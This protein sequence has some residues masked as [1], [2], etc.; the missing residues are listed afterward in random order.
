MPLSKFK[1]E[2]SKFT[3]VG[4]L[5]FALTFVVFFLLLKKFNI[6]YALALTVTWVVGILFSYA[7]NSSWV[8]RSEQRL[9]FKGRFIKYFS[10][11]F[12]SFVL[13][14]FVLNYFVKYRGYDPF[15]VQAF[16]IPLIVIFNFST[17]KYW[18]LRS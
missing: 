17:T 18:S 5:N 11:Y 14:F 6:N 8:F 4:M 3:I 16:L 10:C 15:Y 9:Q 12:V 7:L 1:I 2:I 13:N